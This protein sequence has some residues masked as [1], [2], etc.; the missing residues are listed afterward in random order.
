MNRRESEARQAL[1]Q[2]L[3]DIAR[4]LPDSA[5]GRID[6]LQVRV[7]A[8]SGQDRIGSALRRAMGGSALPPGRRGDGG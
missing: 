8:G 3:N 1:E 6:R 5:S 4:D 2:A 7:P